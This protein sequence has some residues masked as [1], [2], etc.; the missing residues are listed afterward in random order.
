MVLGP[1]L[2]TESDVDGKVATAIGAG[3]APTDAEVTT[4][5]GHANWIRLANSKVQRTA[6]TTLVQ[7]HDNTVARLAGCTA[8]AGTHTTSVCKFTVTKGWK[9]RVLAWW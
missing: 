5:I 2:E 1:G 4:A 7:T 8:T 6:D 9:Y 3:V